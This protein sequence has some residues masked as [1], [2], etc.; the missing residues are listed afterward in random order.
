M[1]ETIH[2]ARAAASSTAALLA[3]A[4]VQ[5]RT[6]PFDR[7]GWEAEV[8]G[9]TVE[10][11]FGP[12]DVQPESIDF[13]D[14]GVSLIG[15][16]RPVLEAPSFVMR[17]HEGSDATLSFW[18]AVLGPEGEVR[19]YGVVQLVGE[20]VRVYVTESLPDP[21]SDGALPPAFSSILAVDPE[22]DGDCTFKA[23]TVT[24]A[25]GRESNGERS[26][27]RSLIVTDSALAWHLLAAPVDMLKGDAG[28]I[29]PDARWITVHPNGPGS[30]G[31][32]VLVVPAGEGGA[33]RVIGGAGGKLNMLKLRGVKSEGE[34][35]ATAAASQADK[36]KARKDQIASRTRRWVSMKPS[37]RPGGN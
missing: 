34:Y 18:R 13:P 12:V 5:W 33:M 35:K 6:I 2:P 21:V 30:K 26:R 32:P 3:A 25:G 22:A 8:P 9:N 7:E 11:P 4:G 10:T 14:V 27:E 23:L 20:R 15:I 36:R 31:Q 17:E 1:I 37:R 28:P 24:F 29:P 19:G 16:L